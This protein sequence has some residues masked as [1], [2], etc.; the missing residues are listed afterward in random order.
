MLAGS[1]GGDRRAGDQMVNMGKALAS[2]PATEE[3]LAR[4]EIGPSQAAIIAGAIADLPDDTTPEQKQACEDTL[5]G[6]AGRF[7]LKDLRN[8]SKRITD[9]FKPAA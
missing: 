2:A 7:N 3:A 9:Q 4:G 5:I 1:F 6:D 8:R